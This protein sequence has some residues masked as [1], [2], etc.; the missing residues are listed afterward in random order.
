MRT[1]FIISILFAFTLLANSQTINCKKF[2]SGKFYYPGIPGSKG[3]VVRDNETQKSYYMNTQNMTVTWNVKW[4]SD[5]DYELTFKSAENGD[6]F[7]KEGD[8]ILATI[9]ETNEDCFSFKSTF[10][11]AKYPQGKEMPLGEMCIK[12]D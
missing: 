11:N 10:Y 7:F 6:G 12:K 2:K 5:C 3:Y 1:I 4:T 9:T 8:K